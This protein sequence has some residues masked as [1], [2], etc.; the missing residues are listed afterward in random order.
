MNDEEILL[1][2][3]LIFK[4]SVLEVYNDDILTSNGFKTKREYIK[5]NGGV[6]CL[7]LHDNMIYFVKQF[8]YAYKK[9]LLELPAGKIERNEKI[10][11]AIKRELMEEVGL[12]PLKL[13]YISSIYPSPGYTNEIIHLYF[14]PIT[15]ISK[16]EADFDEVLDVVKLSI[17]EAYKL[18]DNGDINDAK[19]L[20]LLLKLR[21]VLDK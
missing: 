6:C 21:K 17:S 3:N 10:D 7:A 2:E 16:K 12:E 5:H 15:R 19:T 11:D 8:R 13:E 9:D 14:S 4:G 18:L 20:V 1:K